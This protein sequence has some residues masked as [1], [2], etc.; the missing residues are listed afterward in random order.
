[1]RY[2]ALALLA[3]GCAPF[4]LA[5]SGKA[6]PSATADSK[7]LDILECKDTA[8]QAMDSPIQQARSFATGFLLPG[9]GIAVDYAARKDLYRHAFADCMTARGWTGITL[10]TD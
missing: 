9:V 2:L 5:T 7:R 8:Q 4:H 10:A 1:M 3:V 6:P